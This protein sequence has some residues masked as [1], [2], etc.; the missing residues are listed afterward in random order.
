MDT[1]NLIIILGCILALTLLGII[2]KIKLW[3]IFKLIFNSVLGG[4]LIF[5]INKIGIPFGIHIGLNVVTSMVVGVFGIPGAMLLI[6]L[7]IF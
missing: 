4:F 5:I 1:N 7:K 6:A 2:F 3:K